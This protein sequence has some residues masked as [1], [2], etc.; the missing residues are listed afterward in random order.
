MT[1]EA[2]NSLEF[3]PPVAQADLRDRRGNPVAHGISEQ[4]KHFADQQNHGLIH[5]AK[6][7][8]VHG[9]FDV[10]ARA[11]ASLHS[12][13][14]GTVTMVK[15]PHGG[16]ATATG[17]SVYG[18]DI[19]VKAPSGETVVMRHVTPG[20]ITV[21]GTVHAGDVIGR[22]SPSPEPKTTPPHVHIELWQPGHNPV[23]HHGAIPLSSLL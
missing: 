9:G 1:G 6:G 19:Y 13:I 14:S 8:H 15:A 17:L 12:P 2:H 18:G 4:C 21:G 5:D 22:I 11:N 3:K 16:H 20:A 10:L 23:A 7:H